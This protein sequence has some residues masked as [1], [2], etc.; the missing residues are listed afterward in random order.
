MENFLSSKYWVATQAICAFLFVLLFGYAN[1]PLYTNWSSD[2]IVFKSMGLL[3]EQGGNLYEDLFDHKG[4]YIYFIQFLG[5]LVGSDTGIFYIQ[6]LFLFFSFYLWD[7]IIAEFQNGGIRIIINI[8]TVWLVLAYYSGG[9]LTEDMCW[10]LVLLPLLYSIRSIKKN[11]PLTVKQ[12]FYV[13]LCFGFITFT[14]VNNAYPFVM[15]V[16]CSFFYNFDLRNLRFHALQC[17]Y[18]VIGVIVPAS[19]VF[20][21]FYLKNGTNGI[22]D[23]LFGTFGFNLDYRANS[24]SE[25]NS[26]LHKVLFY[27]NIVIFAL[28]SLRSS[29]IQKKILCPLWLSLLMTPFFLGHRTDTHYLMAVLPLFVIVL[30]LLSYK[31]KYEVACTIF[32]VLISSVLFVK[33]SVLRTITFISGNDYY[34][35]LY[36][37][38]DLFI[39]NLPDEDK[40]CICNYAD[41]TGMNLLYAHNIVQCNR[42]ILPFQLDLSE[43]LR[44][45]VVGLDLDYYNPSLVL[46]SWNSPCG[47]LNESDRLI[48]KEKYKLIK[49]FK[50]PNGE[51]LMQC[52]ARKCK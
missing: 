25:T 44:K 37:E 40:K 2:E 12:F 45:Q 35:E 20:L 36:N 41:F 47:E 43:T 23:M 33:S 29:K 22:E 13:G 38:F 7:K 32:T 16:I 18:F 4:F 15:F 46:V 31:Y 28:L 52:Y 39:Q 27:G 9:D 49:I 24:V 42:V 8:L 14:R 34:T 3:M 51:E 11:E 50:T 10:P 17:L 6:V 5:R 1:T 26:K 48:I 19:I 21:Y 30:S